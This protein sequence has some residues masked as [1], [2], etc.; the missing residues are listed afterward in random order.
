MTTQGSSGRDEWVTMYSVAY[1][2]TEVSQWYLVLN[3]DTDVCAQTDPIHY[4]P[5]INQILYINAT[6]ALLCTTTQT[7]EED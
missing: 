6:E 3:G 1:Q 7:P 5:H 2:L 4:L